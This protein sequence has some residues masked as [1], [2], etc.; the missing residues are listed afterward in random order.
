MTGHEASAYLRER[1]AIRRTAA[2]LAKLRCVGGGPP[3]RKVGRDVIYDAGDLDAWA[4][5]VKSGPLASASEVRWA[6]QPTRPVGE[7]TMRECCT[8]GSGE[9]FSF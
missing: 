6:A 4:G 5:K 7:Q 9:A 3:F 8:A 2:P 1:H